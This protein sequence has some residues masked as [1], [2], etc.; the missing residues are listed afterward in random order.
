[1]TSTTGSGPLRGNRE[2][3]GFLTS[4][5]FV[6]LASVRDVYFGGVFQWLS[7]LDVA[8]TAFALCSAVFLPAALVRDTGSFRILLRHPGRLFWVNATSAMAWL[9]FFY[10]LRTIEPLLVQILFAGIGPLSVGWVDRLVGAGGPSAPASRAERAIHTGLGGALVLAAVVGL[11]GLSSAGPQPLVVAA[12]GVVLA[13]G[14]GISISANTVLCRQLND[15]GVAPAALVSVRFIGAVVGAGILGLASGHDFAGIFS[16]SAAATLFG[17]SLL[18]IVMPIYVNQ[19]GVALAS[20]LTVRVAM[21]IGPVLIFVLQL[22]E[23][24][25]TP[26]PYSLGCGVCYGVFAV[27]AGLARRRAIRPPFTGREASPILGGADHDRSPER[28]GHPRPRTTP[29]GPAAPPR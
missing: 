14:A 25:L 7:P 21:A 9:A 3:A 4:I 23:G 11:A 18:L 2:A 16:R 29:V 8:V 20:P 10:A 12:L 5:L 22:I 19:I 17:G 6:L 13:A 27:A 15:A 1:M 28:P 26:S 24:R